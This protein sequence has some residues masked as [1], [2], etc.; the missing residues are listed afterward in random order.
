MDMKVVDLQR[1]PYYVSYI[2]VDID[3]ET[4][5]L[6]FFHIKTQILYEP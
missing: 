3:V 4:H 6:F 2:E 5:S 1:G